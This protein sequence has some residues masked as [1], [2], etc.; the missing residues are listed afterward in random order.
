MAW[1][2]PTRADVRRWINGRA[3]LSGQRRGPPRVLIHIPGNGKMPDT[4]RVRA[5][6]ARRTR[7]YYYDGYLT[8]YE[9]KRV[10][11]HA[12]TVDE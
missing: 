11:P 2:Q 4:V 7:A 5:G 3:C 8:I 1:A 6:H 9:T 10:G 12:E